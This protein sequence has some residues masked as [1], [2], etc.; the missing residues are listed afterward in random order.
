MSR[1]ADEQREVVFDFVHD[2]RRYDAD[3]NIE[4]DPLSRFLELFEGVDAQ[5]TSASRAEELQSLLFE[6]LEQRIVDGERNGLD[7][8]LEEALKEKP[9]LAIVE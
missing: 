7:V 1:I 5:S 8:D 2:R 6:R 3:G 9:A 4:Y